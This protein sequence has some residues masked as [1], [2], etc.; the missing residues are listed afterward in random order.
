MVASNVS[1]I[2][3]YIEREL[4]QNNY[5]CRKFVYFN[6][7]FLEFVSLAIGISPQVILVC[8]NVL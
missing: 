4:C 7:N 3:L 5:D 1:E 2:N 6:F 8:C